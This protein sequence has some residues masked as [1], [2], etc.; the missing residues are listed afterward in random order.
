MPVRSGSTGRSRSHV[1]RPMNAFMVWAQAA[2]K[3]LADQYPHLHNAELSKTLGR[4][5]RMLSEDE[6]K[7]FMDEAERLRLKHK[8]DHP[9]YKYQPRRKK[10]GKDGSPEVTEPEITASDLLRV[11]KGEALPMKE[12]TES[13]SDC[14]VESPQASPYHEYS[15][16]SSCSSSTPFSPKDKKVDYAV[17]NDSISSETQPIGES[18]ELPTVSI[19]SLISKP[20]DVVSSSIQELDI[21]ALDQYLPATES[22]ISFCNKTSYENQP[23]VATSHNIIQQQQQQQPYNNVNNHQQL[24]DNKLRGYQ[25]CHSENISSIS[26]NTTMTP[27]LQY[28]YRHNR[29]YTR[30]SPYDSS[31]TLSRQSSYPHLNSMNIS[32][33]I[34]DY[35]PLPHQQQQATSNINFPTTLQSNTH[36]QHNFIDNQNNYFT[37]TN[38]NHTENA[39]ISNEQFP[40]FAGNRQQHQQQQTINDTMNQQNT[41]PIYTSYNN[42][43]QQQQQ[44]VQHSQLPNTQ[45]QQPQQQQQEG[46]T[47]WATQI[48]PHSYYHGSSY[49]RI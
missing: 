7:P 14:S 41:F 3:K 22:T 29:N 15:P 23:I 11:I 18:L 21:G 47:A 13:T 6:K 49:N 9:D 40:Q 34:S 5:W 17:V 4:L 37:S 25:Q 26:A 33:S 35:Q 12:R 46:A 10:Q 32:G 48:Y 38:T 42:I 30:Y 39:I 27:K 19:E 36:L 24:F 44:H 1:K 8:K 31:S 28:P 2:R 20:A 43:N 45:Q 16:K